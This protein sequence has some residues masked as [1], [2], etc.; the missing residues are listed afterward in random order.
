MI[1]GHLLCKCALA[2]IAKMASQTAVKEVVKHAVKRSLT[3]R[4]KTSPPEPR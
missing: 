1:F 3:T 2:G 4:L